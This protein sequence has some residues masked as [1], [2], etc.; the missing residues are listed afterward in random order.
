MYMRKNVEMSQEKR[1][2]FK[3]KKKKGGGGTNR[4]PMIYNK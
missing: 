3:K 1:Q 2:Q 4:V